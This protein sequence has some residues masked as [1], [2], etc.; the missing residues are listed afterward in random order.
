MVSRDEHAGD[1][2]F[3]RVS[4]G[5]YVRNNVGMGSEPTSGRATRINMIT[6]MFYGYD[7]FE[8][9]DVFISQINIS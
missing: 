7:S 2:H 4:D 9:V 6:R 8:H 3:K 5:L 1:I